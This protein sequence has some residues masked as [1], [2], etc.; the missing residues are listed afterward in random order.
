MDNHHPP[1][2]AIRGRGA[3]SNERSR[4]E[5]WRREPEPAPVADP[6]ASA[7]G[8]SLSDAPKI[9]TTVWMKQARS[10]ISANSSPDIP[11]DA[12]I[13]PYQGCEHGCIY[14]YAR[15]SHA[16]I[17]LS[18]GLDFETRVEAKANAAE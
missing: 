6:D 9:R 15:P 16:Y 5:S 12:S 3:C 4:F 14:C 13:N 18:P 10:I 8:D 1:A 7:A 17:G 11:F 2:A